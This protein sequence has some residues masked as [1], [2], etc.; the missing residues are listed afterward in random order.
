MPLSTELEKWTLREIDANFLSSLQRHKSRENDS[1][2]FFLVSR[3]SGVKPGFHD[4]VN[5]DTMAA[6]K[7]KRGYM[8]AKVK[9]I[10]SRG[11]NSK[12]SGI[13]FDKNCSALFSCR[14]PEQKNQMINP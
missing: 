3:C 12:D 7:I 6:S 9:L 1:L 11:F 4:P 14:F 10:E 5:F 2:V 13:E 8:T